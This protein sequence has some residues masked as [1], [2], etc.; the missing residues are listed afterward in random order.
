MDE[1]YI[2]EATESI[3]REANKS[4]AET[5]SGV[6]S[7]QQ[8]G[9]SLVETLLVVALVG[10]IAAAG[11]M[12]F[13][14]WMD[15]SKSRSTVTT[16]RTSLNLARLEAIKRGGNVRICGS[17]NG[18]S[19]SGDLGDGWI[20]FHDADADTAMTGV[21]TLVFKEILDDSSTILSMTDEDGNAITELG[22]NYRGY[23]SQPAIF[24]SRQGDFEFRFGVSSIGRIS[25]L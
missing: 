25:S 6:P 7:R 20:I 2:V 15:N 24:L 3:L 8:R 17:F 23:S 18:T 9:Y 19:C 4:K 5:N 22:F 21:D 14:A 10:S 1:P 12:S 13:T 16:L 11:I